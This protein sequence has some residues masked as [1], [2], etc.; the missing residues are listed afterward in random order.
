MAWQRQPDVR[1]EAFDRSEDSTRPSSRARTWTS[2]TACARP[3]TLVADPRLRNIHLGDPSRLRALFF[4]ELWRG[5]DN[6]RVTCVDE[7][8]SGASE[9][10]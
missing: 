2:A 7:S 1:R 10:G 9:R 5:R 4:G 6:I 3:V 8:P